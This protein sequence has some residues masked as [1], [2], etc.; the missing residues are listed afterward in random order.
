MTRGVRLVPLDGDWLDEAS[1]SAEEAS[2]YDKQGTDDGRITDLEGRAD[3]TD[4][5]QVAQDG[6]LGTLETRANETDTEQG[7]QDGRLDTLDT[8][9]DGT[10]T[11]Q[12]VQD[13]R[14]DTLESAPPGGGLPQLAIAYLS[15]EFSGDPDWTMVTLLLHCNG[16]DGSTLFPDESNSAQTIVANGDAQ[17][18]TAQ[19]KFGTA[20]AI[21][22]GTGDYLDAGSGAD[23]DMS[24]GD[25]CVEAQFRNAFGGSGFE[26]I[27]ENSN[28]GGYQYS[29]GVDPSGQRVQVYMQGGPT[30]ASGSGNLN[31]NQWYHV[32][33][34][35][36]G[37]TIRLFVDGILED[38]GTF[39]SGWSPTATLAIG[40]TYNESFPFTGWIDEVRVTKGAARYT[41]SFTPPAAEFPSG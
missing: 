3:E 12:G 25:F 18:S 34:T 1:R 36:A 32:A 21:F 9:A 16:T 6:R 13:G 11:E 30:L 14:L 40:A 24:A 4:T 37:D 8:R 20:S 7:V 39:A 38:S 31:P 33:L 41:T 17:V 29:I 28:A 23:Y 10:D 19:A 26:T 22:D 35:R 15:A 2:F 27:V 5:E